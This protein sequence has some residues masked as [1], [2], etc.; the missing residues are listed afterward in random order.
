MIVL[1]AGA[2]AIAPATVIARASAVTCRPSAV[3]R[4]RRPLQVPKRRLYGVTF[5]WIKCRCEHRSLNEKL[6]EFAYPLKYCKEVNCPEAQK[7]REVS[8]DE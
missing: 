2:S 7:L 8:A 6:C 5:Q 3:R 4:P 1:I